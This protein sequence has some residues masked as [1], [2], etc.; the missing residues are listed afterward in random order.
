MMKSFRKSKRSS[1]SSTSP[2]QIR[3][4][5]SYINDVDP[6]LQVPKKVIKAIFDYK[7]QS[8]EELSFSKGDF[9][10]V[11]DDGND[12]FHRNAKKLGW[13]EATNPMTHAKGMVP[14]DYF[15]VFDRSRPSA[16]VNTSSS[17]TN[18]NINHSP[19][20]PG[21]K[22]KQTLYAVTLYEFKAEREDELDVQPG[23]NLIICAHHEYEWFIAKPITRLGG[24]GLIPV[25]YVQII[26]VV[27][28]NPARSLIDSSNHDEM[29]KAIETFKIPT[30][31]EWKS[32]TAKYQASTIPLGSISGT[33]TPPISANSQYFDAN[34]RH[35]LGSNRSS[36]SSSNISILEANVESYQLDQGRYQYLV[37]AVL[38]NG[39]IR[40]LYR[41]YQDFYDLQ[42]KLLEL[43]PYEAGK[44][45][46]S[47]RIIPSIP[48]PLITVNDSISKLRREKLDF[49]LRNLIALPS[50]ISRCEEVLKLFEVLDNGF[51]RE[52]E[53]KRAS[54]PISQKSSSHNDRLS[55]YSNMNNYPRVS[56]S[57][58]NSADS[59]LNNSSE[60]STTNMTTHDHPTNHNEIK[61]QTKIKVKFYFEDDIFVLLLPVNLRLEDLKTRLHSRLEL[62]DP[63]QHN[64]D[65]AKSP[66]SIQLY[67][68]NDFEDFINENGI[69]NQE[70][71]DHHLSKLK[72]FEVDDDIKF[73]D[74][75]YDKCKFVILVK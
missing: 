55:Q 29:V 49:Y 33:Q 34:Q 52:T 13:Y 25:S 54:K 66:D 5:G 41:Y 50:H 22:Q 11:L 62:G 23:E 47:K 45:E 42:V 58:S 64:F 46:N 17:N 61:Q 60:S 16:T 12:E 63:S 51:D 1:S 3:V 44:I 36:L 72:E 28:K 24:P 65:D 32:Q 67:L 26:D 38:S 8:S 14:I 31:E 6:V 35:H 68:K 57:I 56:D 7:A 71:K 19:V 39:R 20:Q 37:T 30:V 9:F 27:G 40:Y 15:E 10:H 70:F 4:S 2:R 59:G 43:F 48:G 75:L 74:V 73:H 21:Q 18:N 53:L 69:V